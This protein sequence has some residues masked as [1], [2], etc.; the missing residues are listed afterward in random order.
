[1]LRDYQLRG[2]QWLSFLHDHQLGGLLADDMGLGK[3]LQAL[4]MIQRARNRE[5]DQPPFLIVAPTSVVGNWRSEAARFAP[6]LD[7]VVITATLRRAGAVLRDRIADADVVITSYALFRI[8]AEQYQSTSW[9]GLVLDEAQMIKNPSSQ[10]YLAARDLPTPFTVA[11]TGTP[12]E[13]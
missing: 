10:G 3:T 7:L 8:E 13:N 4:T 5:P 1:D 2:Y 9:S 11:I 12:L 6:E